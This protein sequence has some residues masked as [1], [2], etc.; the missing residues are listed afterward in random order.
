MQGVNKSTFLEAAT[1]GKKGIRALVKVGPDKFQKFLDANRAIGGSSVK[2]AVKETTATLGS[3]YLF[4]LILCVAGLC[5][6]FLAFLEKKTREWVICRN[7]RGSRVTG[8][9]LLLYKKTH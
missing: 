3:R 6:A 7:V 5:L 9:P 4:L 2:T 1:F 8:C